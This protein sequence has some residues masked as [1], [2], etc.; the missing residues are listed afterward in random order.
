MDIDTEPREITHTVCV[1]ACVQAI[2]HMLAEV[3]LLTNENAALLN[4]RANHVRD[5]LIEDTQRGG[6]YC[7]L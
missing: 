2:C 7:L 3:K 5:R 1:C 4:H 6:G